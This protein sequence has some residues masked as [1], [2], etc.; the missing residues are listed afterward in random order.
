MASIEEDD[1]P[2]L[3][4]LS[5]PKDD[6]SR[7]EKEREPQTSRNKVPVTIITG[8]LGAGKTT[9]LNYILTE[10]H[11]K[12]IAVILN[13]FGEGSAVE[14]SMAVGQSG[15][16]YEEWLELRNGCLCCSVRDAGVKA[17]ENL[18]E[19][20]GKFD[21]ILLETTG[22]ADPGPIASIFWLDDGLGS[23]LILDGNKE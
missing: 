8:F 10:Q 22:L 9:L 11:N 23:S 15:E 12:R 21:Y 17:I 4:P 19:Y 5:F 20:K 13:E 1:I 6:S 18:M 2:E 16:L 14:K 3:V 7:Q